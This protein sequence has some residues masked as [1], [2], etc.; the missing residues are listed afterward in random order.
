MSPFLLLD[1]DSSI[2]S[3]QLHPFAPLLA[4]SCGTR[5]F[6]LK[7]EEEHYEKESENR[8][9]V[10]NENLT[11]SADDES[12]SANPTPILF[13]NRKNA[14]WIWQLPINS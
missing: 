3:V 6:D 4:L 9:V 7:L 8:S 11:A 14:T 12:V 13:D 5:K 10:Q 1:L 2:N